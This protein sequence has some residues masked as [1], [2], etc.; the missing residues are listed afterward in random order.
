MNRIKIVL[1][2]QGRTQKWLAEKIGKSQVIVNGYCN[3]K[4]QPRLETIFQ[5]ASVLNVDPRELIEANLNN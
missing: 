5:I 2:E 4:T 1:K 3:N